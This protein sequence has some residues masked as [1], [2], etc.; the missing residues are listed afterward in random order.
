MTRKSSLLILLGL[1]FAVHYSLSTALD[2]QEPGIPVGSAG[3]PGKCQSR[4]STG[5]T[6]WVDCGGGGGAV[7]SVFGRTGA[8]TAQANDYDWD[9][10][11]SKPSAF[12]PSAH[13]HPLGEITDLVNQLAAKAAASHTHI[14]GDVTSLQQA[15]DAKAAASHAHAESDVTNLVTDLA[16]KQA[17]LGF[18]PENAANK[19]AASGYAGID[20]NSRLAAAQFP[21]LTGSITTAGGS[22]ATSLTALTTVTGALSGDVTMTTAGTFYDGPTNALTAAKWLLSGQV[23]LQTTS[24]TA[25]VQFVCKLWDGSTVVASPEAVAGATASA[26]VKNEPISLSGIV[27]P[28][29]AATCKISC[30]SNTASQLIKAATPQ[31]GAGNNASLLNAVRLQ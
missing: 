3:Q 5:E 9:K 30:T 14:I 19:N 25:A 21:A 28:T 6:T 15:L 13:A 7:S 29:G 4:S 18:T 16:G 20:A 23:T 26:S 1:L 10:I 27:T 17:S 11:A 22:L 12:S 2:A 24:V 31:Y 8:V